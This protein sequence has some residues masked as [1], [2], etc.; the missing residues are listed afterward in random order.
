MELTQSPG[1]ARS[2]TI[3]A[4]VVVIGGGRSLVQHLTV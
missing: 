2:S 3:D 1:A 4:D